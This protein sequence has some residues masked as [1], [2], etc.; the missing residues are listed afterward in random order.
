MEQECWT[1]TDS[2]LFE[3]ETIQIIRTADTSYPA[4]LYKR[5]FPAVSIG[6]RLLINQTATALKL[7]SGGMIL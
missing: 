3:D 1:V 4:V 7:G 6:T 2:I 5:F